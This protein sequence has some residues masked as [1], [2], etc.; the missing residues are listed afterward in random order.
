MTL[1]VSCCKWLS[2]AIR[3]GFCRFSDGL[4][5]FRHPRGR[6][7]ETGANTRRLRGTSDA[8]AYDV[9]V[10]LV[11]LAL[12][13]AW[14]S[15]LAFASDQR[16]IQPLTVTRASGTTRATC[17]LIH[18][19]DRPEG[20]VL[21]F[22]TAG[23][24]FKTADGERL[25][26]ADSIVV[27][28]NTD[29][30]A[31]RPQDVLVPIGNVVDVALLRATVPHTDL[32]PEPVTWDP[33]PVD[34]ALLVSGFDRSGS[35]TGIPQRVRFASTTLIV[36]D[37]D[38]STLDGC[39][40][41]PAAAGGGTFGMV[42]S[43]EPG[44]APLM[45]I[46]RAARPFIGHHIPLFAPPADA[47]NLTISDRHITGPVLDVPCEGVNAG[48]IDVPLKLRRD[49]W[50]LDVAPT[51][52]HSEEVHLADISVMH[53]GDRSIKLR[54]SVGGGSPSPL[55]IG[56]SQPQALVTLRVTLVTTARE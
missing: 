14:S 25:P 27:G 51:L 54:F 2:A 49:E 21:Y 40:G 53:V 39:I 19:D 15:T 24:V 17:T 22:V 12:T 47:S 52:I 9:R 34:G 56:C 31:I 20:I 37:H 45:T 41:A 29:A 10:I 18:R 16:G 33:P 42:T 48:E 3:G 11:V 1:A 5:E 23:R 6:C 8:H 50:V 44:K 32:A 46:L 28:R 55:A 26:Q 43:C 36:G 7:S 4:P 35:A 38:A 13:A 30:L